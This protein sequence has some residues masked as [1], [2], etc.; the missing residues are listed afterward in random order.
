MLLELD[1]LSIG[2]KKKDGGEHRIV[3]EV[4]LAL[5]RGETFGLLGASGTGKTLLAYAL[6]GLLS[7]PV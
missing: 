6:C 1:H 2:L 3:H 4:S 7:P 5:Q